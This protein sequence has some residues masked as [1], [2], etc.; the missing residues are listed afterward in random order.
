MFLNFEISG[1]IICIHNERGNNFAPHNFGVFRL[2]SAEGCLA[3]LSLHTFLCVLFGE[4]INS[5]IKKKIAT[6]FIVSKWYYFFRNRCF[7]S[8]LDPNAFKCG[9][10]SRS[11]SNW[12]CI[13]I[14]GLKIWGEKIVNKK[15]NTNLSYLSN[16]TENPD[17][18]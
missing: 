6:N 16:V 12:I 8:V 15:F 9:S 14:Q 1:Q 11:D 2:Y 7:N 5:T 17:K 3:F 18:Y 13:Q 4:K 10:G